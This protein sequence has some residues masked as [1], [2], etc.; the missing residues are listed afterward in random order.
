MLP[1][2]WKSFLEVSQASLICPSSKSNIKLKASVILTAET[3]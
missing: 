1:D 2:F 3:R